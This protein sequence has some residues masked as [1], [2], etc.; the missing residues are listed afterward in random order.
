MR[1]LT[2]HAVIKC[3]HNGIVTNQASQR[4]VTVR[5]VA[6]L[7]ADDPVGRSIVAC[8]NYGLGRKPCTNT[9]AVRTG[10]STF[11]T[12]S[13]HAVCLDTLVGVT[14]GVDVEVVLYTVRDPA[15]SLVEA[16]S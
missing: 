10:Y 13:G 5:G 12:V 7:I 11:V 9:R 3:G 2:D 8:P 15:Q 1:M 14:D 6:V 16:A 4:F